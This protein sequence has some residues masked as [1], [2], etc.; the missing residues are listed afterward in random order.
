MAQAIANGTPA[1]T[2]V[3][4]YWADISQLYK[5]ATAVY[6]YAYTGVSAVAQGFTAA[7]Q[8]VSQTISALASATRDLQGFRCAQGTIPAGSTGA[9]DIFITRDGSNGL[10][11]YLGISDN[12]SAYQSGA[13]AT[14]DETNKVQGADPVT[15]PVR[16][17]LTV[18]YCMPD[19]S[20]W[21]TPYTA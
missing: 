16:I 1:T 4:K 2:L 20:L 21:A 3:Q 15:K 7:G 5:D 18:Q 11:L 13:V 12:A 6:Q 17:D 9:W 10:V 8:P 14:V 19:T